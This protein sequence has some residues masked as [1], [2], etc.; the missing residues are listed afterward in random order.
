MF[1]ANLYRN[2]ELQDEIEVMVATRNDD[3][4]IRS[5]RVQLD[6]HDHTAF[7]K[8]EARDMFNRTFS[9]AKPLTQSMQD[10]IGALVL[11]LKRKSKQLN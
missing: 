5:N 9:Y 6:I 11:G 10:A 8:L 3:R 7:I 4:F 2:D 1:K